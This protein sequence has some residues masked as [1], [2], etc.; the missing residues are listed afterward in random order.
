MKKQLRNGVFLSLML[1]LSLTTY[2]QKTALKVKKRI[3]DEKGNTSLVVFKKSTNYSIAQAKQGL[4]D[5]LGLTNTKL[6]KKESKVDA[7]GFTHEK[8]QQYY[9]GVKVEFGEYSFHS[10]SGHLESVS[11]KIYNIGKE[12]VTPKLSKKAAFNQALAHTGAEHYM[13]EYPEAAKE[14]DN[15]KK[16]EGE[17]VLLPADVIGKSEARLAYKF[18]I[19]ATEP[20][21]RGYLYIDAENGEALFFNAIIKHAEKFGH[22]S[23]INHA[24]TS[25]VNL[26][27]AAA[28]VAGSAQ[29]RY[30]GT[31]SI[32]TTL[33]GSS[34]ILADAGR[35]VY[36]RDA[37]NQ[38]TTN[39]PYVSNYSEFT[40]NDNN[41]TSA[42]HSNG[43]DD[44]ALDAHWGAMMT[45]D[46]FVQEHNRN[47][48]DD[49]GAQIR[50]YVHVD[51]NYDNAFWNGSVM[52]YGDGSSNGNEGNGNF[53]ALTSIDVA[54]HEIGHAICTYTADLAYQRES[55]GLNEGF[56]DIWG[57]AVEHFAKGNGNDLAP[58]E[59]VWLIGDEIDR[60]SG[61][62]ALRSMSNPTSQGQPDTYGGTNWINPQCGTPTST[63]DYCGVHTNSGV[64]NYWFYLLTV[65][66][67]DTND[68]GDAFSVTAIGI[69]KAAKIA[70][71]T[72]ANYLSAN[73]TFADARA[74]AIQSAIDLYGENSQEVISTTNAWHAVNVGNAY[75]GGDTGGG[76][77][78]PDSCH[79][80]DVALSIT[81][82]NYPE[83]TSWS[84][85]DESGS[86]VQSA[87]YSTSNAD[88][89]TVNVTFSDLDAGT[90]TF[91]IN[92]QYGDGICC[93]Y[94]NG[95]YTLSGSEGTIATGGDFGESAATSFCIEG[96]GGDT[97]DTEAPTT[98]SGLAT[99]NIEET[100]VTLSW[101]ASSDNVAVTGY[102]IYQGSSLL[103]STT[104]TSANITGLTA[105]TAYTFSVSATDEAGNESATASVSVTTASTPD[106]GGGADLTYCDS[107]GN[108]SSY[109]WIDY[110]S[111][112]GIDNT[113]S[114][115]G[116][117]ADYTSQT[118]TVSRGATETIVFSCGFSNSSYTEYW[119]V[120]ID[121]NQDGTFADSEKVAE[122]SSSSAE[123]LSADITI[124]SDASLGATRM[125]VSMKYNAAQTACET[126]TYGE[127]EDYTV[128]VTESSIAQAF[129]NI[130]AASGDQLGFEEATTF[131]VY[132]NPATNNITVRLNSRSLGISY[133]IVNTIGQAVKQGDLTTETVNVSG[134]QSGLYLL[135]VNDGQKL[136]TTKFVKK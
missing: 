64:L 26:E 97:A 91:T 131:G 60:R 96:N 134:L 49:N 119:A 79:S 8:Q 132:P 42:E 46:Y 19:F 47:S 112:A 101:S 1:S 41:W 69:S 37:E 123:N 84:L 57:A 23:E 109:E 124:P 55:G 29:T 27:K 70:Y 53:D 80:G 63:N 75:S 107:Q 52:S 82:D 21:S 115:D 24:K 65:G 83:E 2:A 85:T 40:D 114:N 43:K 25:S 133:R 78:N 98:P 121:F 100:S 71:R 106:D 102:N 92:D 126:F 44:A 103:G 50:S 36:T 48:F 6:Q 51:N 61:S 111:F 9:K 104:S 16:P 118:A 62:A 54:A 17:L 45:Y 28:F 31:R 67:N 81:F 35:K 59:S 105:A 20:I 30:S 136:L 89:S 4:I 72:E 18:D 110:V 68:V 99:S 130:T 56:S 90:Y 127:V 33:S 13:W 12:S 73:S 93:S 120:W 14:M 34:Y 88:G 7:L 38:G 77:D 94:G 125:R 66:G 86:T 5:D 129:G 32:E 113:T 122:G 10:K 39:Y 117:Y 58:D 74:G 15:Y 116:G 128:S 87:S 76:T 3:V 11:G 108:D 135:E 22:V 95:S